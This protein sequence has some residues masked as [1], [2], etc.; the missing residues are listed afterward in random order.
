[1]SDPSATAEANDFALESFIPFQL[2]VLSN[3]IGE[4]ISHAYRRQH[5]LSVTE[6]RVLAI[7]GRFPGLTA[8]EVMDRGAMDK[9]AVSRAVKKLLARGLME[10]SAHSED[11]RRMPL[12][13][14]RGKGRALFRAVVP[15]A[16]AYERALI[17]ALTDRERAD[18]ERALG[19]LLVEAKR[20]TE[21]AA[22][23]DSGA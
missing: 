5:G 7:V 9:V 19:K 12:T 23:A 11:R 16:I 14:T 8:S 15:R 10:R 21:R 18:F 1:M 2:S 17:Q 22:E 13:L 20:L 6:W 4:G 3:I